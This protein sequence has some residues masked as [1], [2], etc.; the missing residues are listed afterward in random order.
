MAG[1]PHA[2]AGR[3]WL[4]EPTKKQI[5]CECSPGG[6]R[7]DGLPFLCIHRFAVAYLDNYAIIQVRRPANIFQV[8]AEILFA[9]HSRELPAAS[10]EYFLCDG[11]HRY[12]D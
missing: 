3:H 1:I 12:F 5:A 2:K 9:Y 6:V 7:A 4:S 10:V 11:M 8:V